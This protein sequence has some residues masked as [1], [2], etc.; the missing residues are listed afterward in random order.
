MP[1]VHLYILSN[2]SLRIHYIYFQGD[3]DSKEENNDSNL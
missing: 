1:F 2:S 3:K